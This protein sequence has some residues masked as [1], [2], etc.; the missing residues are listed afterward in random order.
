MTKVLLVTDHNG[1]LHI[2]PLGNLNYYKS[3]NER[4]KGKEQF[5]FK[6][7][8]EKE[9]EAFVKK[10]KGIDPDF[11]KPADAKSL[12][13]EKNSE[14]EAK[15]AEIE[16]LKAEL[17]AAKKSASKKPEA[18]ETEDNKE[19]AKGGKK[20]KPEASETEDNK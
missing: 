6:E 4:N 13:S 3:Q 14:L 7:L 20:G 10:N 17:E 5:T 8:E 15:D 2:T 11:V 1:V 16:K 19:A 12:L 9:A 18:S